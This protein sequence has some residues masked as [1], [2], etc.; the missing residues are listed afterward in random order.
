M[1]VSTMMAYTCLESIS[2]NLN[3]E[4]FI[5]KFGAMQYFVE[6]YFN[7]SATKPKLIIENY[8]DLFNHKTLFCLNDETLRSKE[9]IADI[10]EKMHNQVP[11]N[12]DNF[13]SVCVAYENFIDIDKIKK[14]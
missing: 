10:I 4:T 5:N 9:E 13:N 1:L 14:M 11:I 12:F 8:Y 6:N 7:E 3:V 2:N